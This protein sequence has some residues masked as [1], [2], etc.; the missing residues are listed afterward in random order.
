MALAPKFAGQKLA[1]SSIQPKAVHTIEI[2]RAKSRMCVLSC[3]LILLH[4]SRLCLPLQ[5]K[6][7]QNRIRLR[8]AQD[9]AREVWRPRGDHLPPAD[10]A[11][12][13][14]FYVSPRGRL[15]S[16]EGRLKQVLR[17]LREAV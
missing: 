5:C 9:I 6:D 13:P 17:L 16:A 12:A 15:R 14:V 2:C 1:S 10:S 8:S 3:K 11:L 4:R 7:F